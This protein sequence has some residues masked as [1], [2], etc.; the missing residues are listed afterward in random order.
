MNIKKFTATKLRNNNCPYGNHLIAEE[1]TYLPAWQQ[2]S[3]ANKSHQIK[4]LPSPFTKMF[5][6]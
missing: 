4:I 1:D 6:R 5:W 3:K 2:V